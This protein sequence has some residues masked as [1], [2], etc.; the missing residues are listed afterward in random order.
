M[1]LSLLVGKKQDFN[2]GKY[3]HMSWKTLLMYSEADTELHTTC[4]ISWSGMFVLVRL[5]YILWR[6]YQLRSYIFDWCIIILHIADNLAILVNSS[7]D[8]QDSW[9]IY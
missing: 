1:S 9:T 8:L 4:D 5:T 2:D 3:L 6:K 7:K